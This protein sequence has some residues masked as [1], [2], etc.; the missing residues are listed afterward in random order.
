M[1]LLLLTHTRVFALLSLSVAQSPPQILE[2]LTL[3]S[4]TL[5]VR[6][7]GFDFIGTNPDESR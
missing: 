5:L 6:C 3:N 7:L 1:P 2:Q 4:L